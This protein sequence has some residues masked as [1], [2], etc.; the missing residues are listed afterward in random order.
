MSFKANAFRLGNKIVAPN[1]ISG[2]DEFC[3]IANILPDDLLV[4]DDNGNRFAVGI[5]NIRG[6]PLINEILEKCGLLINDKPEEN[7][8]YVHNDKFSMNTYLTSETVYYWLRY[9]NGLDGP[10]IKYLHELQ[11]VY[12]VLTGEEIQINL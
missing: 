12:F 10:E 9:Y 2:K 1:P 7:L 4:N 11:N 6:I 3:S 5:G 8:R